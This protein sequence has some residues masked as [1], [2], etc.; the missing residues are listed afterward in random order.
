MSNKIETTDDVIKSYEDRISSLKKQVEELEAKQK[1]MVEMKLTFQPYIDM[2]TSSKDALFA[3]A[4]SNDG[5]T[6]ESFGKKWLMHVKENV[7]NFDVK[8]ESVMKVHREYDGRPGIVAGSGPSLKKNYKQL[9]NRPSYMSLT[10]CL[11]NYAFFEDKGIYPEYYINLDA[12]DITVEELYQGGSKEAQ[13]YWDSTKN[14]VLIAALVSNPKLISKWKG[15][16]LWYNTLGPTQDFISALREITDFNVVYNVG[17]NT[18]G[19]AMYHCRAILG[20]CPVVFVGADFSFDYMK[21]FHPFDSPYDK[22]FAGVIPATDIFGNRVYTWQSYYNFKAWFDYI[23]LGGVGNNPS[24]YINCTEGGILGSYPDGNIRH[25]RQMSLHDF[26]N[27]YRQ[28][29]ALPELLT[30]E[31]HQYSFLF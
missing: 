12:G 27:M 16:I 2:P 1:N 5:V 31:E 23:S 9:K 10:S 29:E 18:L 21:K 24:T 4:C 11:H 13:Y 20:C 22:Q 17:G 15:K 28:S 14:K 6:L 19:A 8:E 30:S 26:I 25:I 3:T 7:D